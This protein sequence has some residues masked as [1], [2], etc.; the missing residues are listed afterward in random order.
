MNFALRLDLRTMMLT[1]AC[2]N[3]LFAGL[4]AL[5]SLH[6]G[7]VK[8]ARHW[9][10]GMVLLGTG[11]SSAGLLVDT[12][13]AA[14]MVILAIGIGLGLG[15]MFNGIEAFKERPCSYRLT[16]AVGL[17]MGVQ[18]FWFLVVRHDVQGRIIANWLVHSAV[19][20]TCAGALFVRVPQPLRTA[21]W[22][23]GA[24]F[25][26][27][28]GATL[29]RVAAT[30]FAPASTVYLF[31]PG[32]ISPAVFM[33][34]SLAQM[35]LAIGLILMINYRMASDLRQRAATD[36][37]TGLLNRG[38]I[39]KE[40]SRQLAVA[41][42]SGAALALM[43]IDIDHFKRIN[44]SHG[45]P[46][47]DEV[48]RQ[49]A[50]LMQTLVRQG[51]AVGRYGGEEFC[52]VLPGTSAHEASALAAR[53]LQQFAAL[54]VHWNGAELGSTLSI[55]LADAA[56]CGNALAP[57]I[58]AAD[59]ALYRAKKTGRNRMVLDAPGETAL[60]HNHALHA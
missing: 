48:L 58:G 14:V 12:P 25:L 4:L 26:M 9:A 17:L 54:R 8:G 31:A 45:H 23:T 21:Y 19:N 7:K 27:L 6:A 55:G 50:R 15:L 24:A 30:L 52:I 3:L 5:V 47:G 28:G 20:L 49:L 39:D 53:L 44:D 37:L 43:M 46:A 60:V 10:A 16:L 36:A 18:T 22:L 29:A 56:H 11:Y 2:I 59:R 40:L 42:R 33:V 57:L 1:M 35:V 34:G 32:K 51:D 13:P 38:S 41:Q